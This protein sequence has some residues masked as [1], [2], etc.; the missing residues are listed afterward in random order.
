M[1]VLELVTGLIRGPLDTSVNVFLFI[2][3]RM[4]EGCGEGEGDGGETEIIRYDISLTLFCRSCL[5]SPTK[6]KSNSHR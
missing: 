6:F 3:G 5:V 4:Q 2:K 1:T